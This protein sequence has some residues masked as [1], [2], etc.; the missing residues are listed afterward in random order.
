MNRRSAAV[1]ASCVILLLAG[2]AHADVVTDWNTAAL[3]AIKAAPPGPPAAARALAM[4]HTAMYD[5]NNAITH[6]GRSYSSMPTAPTTADRQCAVAQSAHDV[7]VSL[8]PTQAA[9]LDA[10]LAAELQSVPVGLARTQGLSVGVEVAANFVSM[11]ASDGSS[12]PNPWQQ[13]HASTSWQPTGPLQAPQFNQYA[14]TTPWTMSSPSMFRAGPPPLPGS[15]AFQTAYDEVKAFGAANSAVRTEDQTNI[16]KYWAGGGG[17]V[18]P[19]GQW[20]LIAQTVAISH[21]T[22]VDDELRLFA[23]LNLAAADAAIAAW[24]MKLYYDYF[25]PIT[26]IRASDDPT[27]TPLLATPQFQ[28]YSSGHSLFSAASAAVLASFFG[29]STP[30][31]LTLSDPSLGFTDMTRSFSSFSQAAEEAGQSRIYGGIHW[32]FD[33][34]ASLDAGYALGEYIAA[35]FVQIPSP[36]A[37]WTLSFASLGVVLRRRRG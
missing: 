14:K 18:T 23:Q 25:R 11:R 36:G 37:A 31:S 32:Q 19:P 20:N 2:S 17:T 10:R 29:D 8:F 28:S 12:G 4:M 22:T 1:A 27:W 3:D 9:A 34:Q 35:N 6:A 26:A 7:L 16:A 30:F 33:N 5:A 13:G 21:N 24:D 15:A